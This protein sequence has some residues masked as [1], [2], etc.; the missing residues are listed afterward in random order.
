MTQKMRCFD[1]VFKPHLSRPL[2][3]IT[4]ADSLN[5]CRS[6]AN[7]VWSR[8]DNLGLAN[9][10][11]LPPVINDCLVADGRCGVGDEETVSVLYVGAAASYV[12]SARSN[13]RLRMCVRV[14]VRVRC[15]KGLHHRRA[16][17]T[18]ANNS[19]GIRDQRVSEHTFSDSEFLKA[20]EVSRLEVC[21]AAES[22]ASIQN[23]LAE[24]TNRRSRNRQLI[25]K[26]PLEI[27]NRFLVKS[28]GFVSLPTLTN[29]GQ[30]LLPCRE[31]GL[32]TLFIKMSLRQFISLGCHKSGEVT[33][34]CVLLAC[35]DQT[36]VSTPGL[37][38]CGRRPGHSVRCSRARGGRVRASLQCVVEVT[39]LQEHPQDGRFCPDLAAGLRCQ[40]LDLTTF[41]Q[42]HRPRSVS[43]LL[44][45]LFNKILTRTNGS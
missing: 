41:D 20:A 4:Q 30:A 40:T 6:E 5:M 18:W 36:A 38:R 9:N 1:L 13:T 15:T 31:L 29:S 16:T 11:V 45:I 7:T 37:I 42:Y 19:R 35:H 23:S 43:T 28:N 17:R 24:E 8:V 10:T 39:P 22:A 2:P 27:F 12:G 14:R 21:A 33:P 26:R 44:P 32:L 34:S 25:A 3:E